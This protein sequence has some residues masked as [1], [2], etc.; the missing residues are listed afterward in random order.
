M[1]KKY[2]LEKKKRDYMIS[3]VNNKAIRVA[4]QIL[5]GKVMRKC[6]ADEVPTSIVALAEQCA[7]GAQFN[8]SEY[9]CKEFLE[10]CRK[11]EEQ[12][13]AFHYAWLLLPIALVMGE[14]PEDSQFPIIVRDL[15]E[16]AKYTSPWAT[17]DA[18]KIR[19]NKIF[20]VF[21]GP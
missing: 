8:W 4:T 19:D 5:V 3:S 17:K 21:V 13:K 1:K 14:F 15:P 16:A 7:E 2:K 18:H 11:A 10:N 9:L 6:C 12:G 20:W